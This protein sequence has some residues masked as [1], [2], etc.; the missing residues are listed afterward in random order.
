M[1]RP[2]KY[3]AKIYFLGRETAFSY[4]LGWE[5]IGDRNYFPTVIWAIKVCAAPK[6]MLFKLFLSEKYIDFDHTC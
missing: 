6:G 3:H 4:V 5:G 2:V 1:C